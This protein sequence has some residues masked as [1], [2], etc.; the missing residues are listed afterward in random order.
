MPDDISVGPKP[1]LEVQEMTP[2][3]VHSNI[4]VPLFNVNI[5]SYPV[6]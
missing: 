5:Y 2:G 4:A 6:Q 3:P 1:K